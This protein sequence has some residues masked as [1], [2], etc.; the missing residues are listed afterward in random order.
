MKS[1]EDLA[2]NLQIWITWN[3]NHLTK[4]LIRETKIDRDQS[5]QK[6]INDCTNGQPLGDSKK[7]IWGRFLR[8]NDFLH[9]IYSIVINV[10]YK[11][12]LM[13]E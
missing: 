8:K 9:N 6:V 11:F 1:S 2:E 13:P 4:A 7:I 10:W 12:R 5:L 3:L